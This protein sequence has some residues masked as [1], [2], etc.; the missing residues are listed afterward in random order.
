[1]GR[2][3]VIKT[4]HQ[5]LKFLSEQQA[6]TPYQ[7][8]WVSK[9]L[10]YNYSI[11][12]RKGSQNIVADALSKRTHAQIHQC[13]GE[14]TLTSSELWDKILQ[15]NLDD[16]K[17]QKLSNEL[18]H[19]PQLHSKY[20]WDGRI[21]TRKGKMMIGHNTDL[22][23]AIFDLFHSEA[24][25]GHSG[26]HTMRRRIGSLLYWKGLS[27][28]VKQW[29]QEYITCQQYKS[30]N[31]AYPGLLQPLPIPDRAW[32]AVSMDFIEGI[33]LSKGKSTI[34]VVVDR[35][36]K[37]AHFLALA[38]PF[39]TASVAQLYLEHVYKLHNTPES[40]VSDR[41]KIFLSSFW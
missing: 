41:D 27:R 11:I 28:D 16:E 20:S 37:H 26:I 13:L 22:R 8:K 30:D 19:N 2:Q 4:D 23:R 40:I 5:S 35:L 3:F 32:A 1:M 38:H 31:A 17:L 7:Q 21:L 25:G 24:V 29:V 14:S 6:I 9:M 39:T 36:T 18:L 12:Y 10:E 34:L 33:P 15:A